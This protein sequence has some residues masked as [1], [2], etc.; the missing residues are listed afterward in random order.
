MQSLHCMCQPLVWRKGKRLGVQGQIASHP[1]FFSKPGPEPG[2]SPSPTPE[3][4]ARI[5]G[6]TNRF[7][8]HHV[9]PGHTGQ[10]SADSRL[11]DIDLQ[12]GGDR[13]LTP[14]KDCGQGWWSASWIP[15]SLPWPHVSQQQAQ[16]TVIQMIS[17]S[18]LN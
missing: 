14:A 4:R 9:W 15:R 6:K 7:R 11:E 17:L 8:G 12:G 16:K 2:N 1:P 5:G 3:T 10:R 13:P 18:P